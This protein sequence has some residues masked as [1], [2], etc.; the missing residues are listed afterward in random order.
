MTGYE[1]LV[2]GRWRRIEDEGIRSPG[3]WRAMPLPVT[4]G[5]REL[6]QAIDTQGLHHL[7]IPAGDAPHPEN[8]TSPLAV[9]F[10]EFRFKTGPRPDVAGRYLDVHCRL[11]ELNTQFDKVI[12]EVV[13]AVADSDRPIGAA[14]TTVATWRR[15]FAALADARPR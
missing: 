10:G 13:D 7:L 4:A 11:T 1:Q 15:L 14:L 9:S 3:G 6:V 5:G 8:T 12:G 2:A